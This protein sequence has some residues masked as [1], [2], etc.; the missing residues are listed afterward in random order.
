MN[1]HPQRIER[2]RAL[3]REHGMQAVLLGTGSN[4]AYFSGYPSPPRSVARPFFCLLPLHGDPVFF[5]HSGHAAEAARFS[6]IPDIRQ[7]QQLAQIPVALIKEAISEKELTGA[8]IGMELG[9]GQA[10]DFSYLDFLRLQAAL[11][12][13]KLSDA[14]PLLWAL[15]MVK[16]KWEISRMRE[17]CNVTGEAYCSAFD[18]AR[19]GMPEREVYLAMKD[20]L[21]QHSDGTIFLAITSGS[22]NYDLV[23][24][25]PEQRRLVAGD[26]VWMDAG[27][28]VDGYWS[29]FSRAGTVGG[30]TDEQ[31][32][33]Q[34]AIH[35]ITSD[36]IARI[37]PGVT[38]SS[39]WRF[40]T[41]ALERLPF[42][43]TSSITQLAARAGHGM[44]LDMT[45]PP[46][47]GSQDEAVLKEGMV[48]TIEPGV[49]TTYGTF[50]VEEN[51]VVTED[52][53]ELL[54]RAPRNLRRIPL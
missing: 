27:C 49:A 19:G 37:R 46:H 20:Y 42:R 45:E 50:H 2:L 47:L 40:C 39:V 3:L 4:L 35:Q 21:T 51:V 36:A 17:A 41:Q 30:P 52:G 24:K 22:G 44:G 54:S 5:T 10:F 12:D 23:T 31:Q 7:Y 13:T 43:I 16:S 11:P 14:A 6:S 29:D 33:A 8:T 34:E 15:R 53:A 1:E 26:L 9:A 18:L 48:I 28:T 32:Y 38:A 25:P